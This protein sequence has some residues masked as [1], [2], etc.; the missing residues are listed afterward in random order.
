[1]GIFDIFKKKK[2]EK[3]ENKESIKEN[4]T[5]NSNIGQEISEE[6]KQELIKTLPTFEYHPNIYKNDIVD[7]RYGICNCCN[8]E[9]KAYVGTMYTGEDVDCICMNCIKDGSAAGKFDGTFIQEA[10]DISDQEKTDILFC[11][12]PGY[13]SWQGEHWIACCDDYCEFIGDVG[14]KELEQL[15]TYD[16]V[17]DECCKEYS[18]EK[19]YL[20]QN[21]TAG[22]T[23]AGYL[24]K[25]KHCGKYHLY[26]DL[27]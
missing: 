24:F 10:E 3:F 21:L 18:W 20:K 23:V 27:S 6:E 15:D 8:K 11:K 13:I 9:V 12:T 4:A 16:E 26:V 25:C 7:F 5:L 19:D 17:I 1:M 22:G 2:V 14:I